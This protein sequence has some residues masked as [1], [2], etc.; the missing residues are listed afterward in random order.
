MISRQ[1]Q[2]STVAE[3]VLHDITP[4]VT[5]THP[6]GAD[7]ASSDSGSIALIIIWTLVVF[8]VTL[9]GISLAKTCCCGAKQKHDPFSYQAPSESLFNRMTRRSS[10]RGRGGKFGRL[11]MEMMSGDRGS[12]S[13]P[14]HGARHVEEEEYEY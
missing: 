10:G 5:S 8:L 3:F 4:G 14:L 9:L 7:R 2:H 13:N 1:G 6:P 11:E 12:N